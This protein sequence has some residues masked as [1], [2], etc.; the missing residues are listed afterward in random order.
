MTSLSYVW[1]LAFVQCSERGKVKPHQI[2]GQPKPQ[3]LR[4]SKTHKTQK[5][6]KKPGDV[7]AMCKLSGK[8]KKGFSP[9]F[10]SQLRAQL[11]QTVLLPCSHPTVKAQ[12]GQGT[13]TRLFYFRLFYFSDFNKRTVSLQKSQ[14]HGASWGAAECAASLP[15]QLMSNLALMYNLYLCFLVI[16]FSF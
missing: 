13:G 12:P 2:C 9:C 5:C 4:K 15:E 7:W 3:T 14:S 1:H 6:C 10:S 11:K 8:I 16:L